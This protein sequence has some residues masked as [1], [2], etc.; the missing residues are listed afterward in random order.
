MVVEGVD[1][2]RNPL[3]NLRKMGLTSMASAIFRSSIFEHRFH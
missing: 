3:E 1:A 2:V